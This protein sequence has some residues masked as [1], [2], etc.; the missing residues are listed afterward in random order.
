MYAIWFHFGIISIFVIVSTVFFAFI[1]MDSVLQNFDTVS[2]YSYKKF[3]IDLP[4]LS[5][6]LQLNTSYAWLDSDSLDIACTNLRGYD[7]P[8]PIYGAGNATTIPGSPAC[9]VQYNWR[10]G[11]DGTPGTPGNIGITSVSIPYPYLCKAGTYSVTFAITTIVGSPKLN[12][13]GSSGL[14][15]TIGA[16]GQATF[17][18][19]GVVIGDGF[20]I[21]PTNYGVCESKRRALV[22]T[23]HEQTDCLTENS[24]MCS[25]IYLFT[26]PLLNSSFVLPQP[27]QRETKLTAHL[28]D[29]IEKCVKLR[30]SRDKY[31]LFKI[32]DH[33]QTQFLFVICLSM[34][35]NILYHM[36]NY[37]FE[38]Q[39][40][41]SFWYKNIG[42]FFLAL[43]FVAVSFVCGIGGTYYSWIEII[44]TEIVMFILGMY[45]EIF[46]LQPDSYDKLYK[47]TIHPCFF[48][49]VYF[50]LS[51]YVMVHRGVMQMEILGVEMVKAFAVS[52][53]YTKII[54]FYA[55]DE[56]ASS[57]QILMHRAQL[58][59]ILLISLMGLDQCF[60]PLHNTRGFDIIWLLPFAWILLGLS[61][62]VFMQYFTVGYGE[63]NNK[64]GLPSAA[65]EFVDIRRNI[66]FTFIHI[67]LFWV[68]SHLFSEYTQF[69]DIHKGVYKY[70]SPYEYRFM[71]RNGGYML[72]G[73]IH[74]GL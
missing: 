56:V 37:S 36:Y 18:K 73:Y 71:M 1:R 50:C 39:G 10:D 3:P 28:Y 19:A 65:P 72:P 64:K 60:L 22:Q 41:A 40:N 14:S 6:T 9:V 66:I 49:I 26:K 48:G 11:I 12:T 52:W 2:L 45:Y 32:S 67:F 29:G 31:E 46:Y 44:P 27:P 55:K 21:H 58:I 42:S 25:C 35:V 7:W 15:I 13:A 17:S 20:T 43:V 4:L 69:V 33:K 16:N 47:P 68:T 53:I 38:A 74:E 70:S 63:E 23:I 34:L 61:E 59:A 8:R 30:R 5:T 54:V 51:S 57:H 24:Q 62:S